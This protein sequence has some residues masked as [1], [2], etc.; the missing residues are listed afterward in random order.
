MPIFL[1]YKYPANPFDFDITSISHRTLRSFKPWRY[2]LLKTIL[3]FINTKDLLNLNKMRP[4]TLALALLP[5]LAHADFTIWSG[6]CSTGFDETNEPWAVSGS[7]TDA[8]GAYGGC[9]TSDPNTESNFSGGNPCNG[10]CNADI[11]DFIWQGGNYDIIVHNTGISV[12]YCEPTSGN[13]QAYNTWSYSCVSV[14]V[15]RCHTY[16]CN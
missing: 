16:Y 5:L 11:L 14:P 10:D 6:T 13:A 1:K 3:N 7:G 4:I 9:T 15:F 12:G 2:P 8:Q